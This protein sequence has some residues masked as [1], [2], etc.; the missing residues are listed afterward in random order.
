MEMHCQLCYAFL[1]SSILEKESIGFVQIFNFLF[2]MDLHVSGCPD[3]D[4]YYFWKMSVYLCLC[5]KNIVAS[6][7]R[8]LMHGIL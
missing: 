6:V 5:D 4:F 8:E 3:Q 1:L 2:S 7:T